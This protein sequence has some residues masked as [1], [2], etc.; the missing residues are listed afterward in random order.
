MSKKIVK[1][2]ESDLVNIIKRIIS[3]EEMTS[4]METD[5]F[6]EYLNQNGI[7][8]S[9]ESIDSL[10]SNEQDINPP[11]EVL[12]R[13]P[14]IRDTWKKIKDAVSRASESELI[15]AYKTISK[16]LKNRKS[17]NEQVMLPTLI[18]ILGLSIPVSYLI[19]IG[20]FSLMFIL[21]RLSKKS[22]GGPGRVAG[23]NEFRLGKAWDL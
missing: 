22:K 12:N 15:N 13:D 2:T 3:E 18:T 9:K 17:T 5:N 20:M 1:L 4:Q 11:E 6:L 19:A 23:R 10:P 14:K 7:Q 8:V 21:A 16:V